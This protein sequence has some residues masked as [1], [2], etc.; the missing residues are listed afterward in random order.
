[1]KKIIPI[2]LIVSM[3]LSLV[4]CGSGISETGN[5]IDTNS[6][7][8]TLG[9]NEKV[10]NT[11]VTMDAG[12]LAPHL[13]GGGL[14]PII[15]LMMEPLWDVTTDG[16][17]IM[18]LCKELEEVSSTEYIVHLQ[19]GVKFH[20]G[21]DFTADDVLFSMQ[22]H[23]EAGST[24]APRVQT[25]DIENSVVVDD[26]TLNLKLLAPTIANWTVLS[27]CLMYDKESYDEV[28]V[29]TTCI[30]TGPFKLVNYVPN[31]EI[32]L[33]KNTEYW[34]EIKGNADKIHCLVLAEDAQRVNALETELV[35]IAQIATTDFE[36][37]NE[38]DVLKPIGVYLG[39]AVMVNFNFGPNSALYQNLEARKAIAHAIDAEAILNT[40][41]LGQGKLMKCALVDYCFDFE[42]RF[43]N[44]SE[45]YS[46][47]YDVELAKQYAESSG[48]VDQTIQ[49]LT[50]GS[51]NNVRVAEMLQGMLSQIGVNLEI[52]NYDSATV[53][54]MMYDLESDWEIQCSPGMAPNRRCGDLLLNGVRYYPQMNAEGAF[55]NS[56]EYL[57]K[58]PDCMSIQDEEELSELLY[59]MIKWYQDELLG[60][61]MF[62]IIQY[63]AVDSKID[64][65]SIIF[66]VGSSSPRYQDIILY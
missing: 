59:E 25:V 9:N 2:L 42:E 21:N 58:A 64:P 19:E 33:E 1:M 15:N 39:N 11:A 18:V 26:Y 40:V 62:D 66:N 61:P 7:S 4:A 49:I 55:E 5:N 50:D 54:Q 6:N 13:I 34:G 27:Q 48:L 46:I 20:N 63:F 45:Q 43:N 35:D 8:D 24:G 17:V 57:A 65:T 22:L 60:Y 23:A 12:T 56:K 41:Y 14:W 44:L 53:W 28:A 36:Y 52:T 51:T 47:G 32:N 31:S 37:V 3:L 29:A 10:L 16:D 30:G 38:H